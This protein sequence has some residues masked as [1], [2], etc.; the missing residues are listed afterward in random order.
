MPNVQDSEPGSSGM[1]GD[2]SIEEIRSW[3]KVPAIA[4][5]C[6]LFGSTYHLPDFEIEDLEE[7]LFLDA[8]QETSPFLPNLLVALLKGCFPDSRKDIIVANYHG[9]LREFMKKQWELVEG[10]VNPLNLEDATFKGLPTLIKVE[11]LHSLCDF[12]LDAADVSLLKVN[13]AG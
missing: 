12:R 6:S 2:V 3:W 8:G 13:E 4:H 11:I 5:F 7:A 9:H 1:S 10:R